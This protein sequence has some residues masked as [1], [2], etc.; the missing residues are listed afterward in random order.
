MHTDVKQG[1][2]F[3]ETKERLSKRTGI[4]GKPFEKI[5]FAVVPRASFSSPKYIEDGKSLAFV[6]S[7]K[8]CVLTTLVDDILSDVAG[9]DD[10]L[11]LDHASKSRG[12]WGKSDSF[13]I[14]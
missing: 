8:V 3:K 4:K 5:K 1:E 7:A 2:I 6:P 11:G 13:F 10:Y 12:F 9:P 14:R